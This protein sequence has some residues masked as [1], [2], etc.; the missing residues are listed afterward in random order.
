ML[1]RA[2]PGLLPPLDREEMLEVTH[3]HSLAGNDYERIVAER[4]FRAPHHG[5]SL[6]SI[7]GGGSPLRPGEISLAHRGVLFFDE[8]PEF[9]REIIETLRQP[10]E[11]RLINVTRAHG[12]AEYPANFIFVATANPCPCGY[13]DSR[14]TCQCPEWQRMLYRNRLSGPI[15][16]RIDLYSDVHDVEYDELLARPSAGNRHRGPPSRVRRA[17]DRQ[18]CPFQYRTKLNADMT[19]D[20]VKNLPF[21]EPEASIHP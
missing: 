12:T 21:I 5:A 6:I 15:F 16:D 7:T 2:L 20:D 18:K 14:K 9:S 1:A 17:R 3:L 13:F 19:D 10:L 8:L 11:N 4:P